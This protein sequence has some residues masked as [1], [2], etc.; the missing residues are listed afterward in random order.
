MNGYLR[1][2]SL[3][4]KFL[5]IHTGLPGQFEHLM[6]ALAREPGHEIV[7]ICREFEPQQYDL[8]AVRVEYYQTETRKAG[9][10]WLEYRIRQEFENGLA[11]ARK[12]ERL[13]RQGFV[14]D[15]ILAHLGWGEPVYCKDILPETPLIG[16]CEWYY[17][18]RNS[19]VDFDPEYSRHDLDAAFQLRTANAVVLAGLA[20]MD[21]GICPTEWQKSQ[22]PLEFQRKIRV[23]HE[24][25]DVSRL[26]PDANASF[27]LPNGE[28]LTR[29]Q[30]I[31]TYAARN[32][33][34]YR[35]FHV[36][37]RAVALLCARRPDCRFV[38]AGGDEVSYSPPPPAGTTY[39]QTMLREVPI[40]PAR[41]Q[42]T[43][44]LPFDDYVKLLQ[45][46]H[47]HV[48]LTVP[49]VPSWSLVEAM[50]AGCAIIGSDTPPVRELL[51]HDRNALLADFFSP[52][53]IADRMDSLLE[54]PIR[55]QA[56]GN[57]ARLDVL[58]NY[59]IAQSVRQYRALIEQLTITSHIGISP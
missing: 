57:A 4:M 25:V 8:S 30:P 58:R 7:G 52:A 21:L 49:F 10:D 24:G 13:K 54:Q 38:I 46:S 27:A 28:V 3:R 16:Y 50:S 51:R 45:I 53:E 35:G 40:D 14:P 22:F 17:Q 43:G 23:L 37:M 48:Y 29:A 11:V 42:F 59:G 31:V 6:H 1:S 5:F 39:R 56:L 18:A 26:H 2:K 36:F 47:A 9:G 19:C 20:A 32:L 12:I 15:V 41:V 55:G 34:P 33:E 44:R